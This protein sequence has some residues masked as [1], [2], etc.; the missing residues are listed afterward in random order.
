MESQE[1][2]TQIVQGLRNK[3]DRELLDI[4]AFCPQIEKWVYEVLGRQLILD[5]SR[6]EINEQELGIGFTAYPEAGF[7]LGKVGVF[8]FEDSRLT[9]IRG[10]VLD[11]DWAGWL[12]WVYENRVRLQRPLA[13]SGQGLEKSVIKTT[14]EYYEKFKPEK[15]ESVRKKLTGNYYSYPSIMAALLKTNGFNV[16]EKKFKANINQFN[17]QI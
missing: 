3:S 1:N 5:K 17:L 11:G 12:G 6:P 4:P 9:T 15:F 13:R 8:N 2:K 10:L 7:I 14:L 16:D